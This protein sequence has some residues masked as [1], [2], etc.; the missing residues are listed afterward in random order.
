MA[1][2]PGVPC[3]RRVVDGAEATDGGGAGVEAAAAAKE[4]IGRRGQRVQTSGLS[5]RELGLR[6][7]RWGGPHCRRQE[8]AGRERSFQH[9]LSLLKQCSAS[10]SEGRC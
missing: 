9:V 3:R 5:D 6:L 1:P 2:P 10:D 7:D 8:A 4:G